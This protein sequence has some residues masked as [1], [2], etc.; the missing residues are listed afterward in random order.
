[1]KHLLFARWQIEIKLSQIFGS[2]CQIT[3]VGNEP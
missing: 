2:E 1:M 3:I